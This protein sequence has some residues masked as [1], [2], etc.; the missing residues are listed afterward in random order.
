[1]YAVHF[2]EPDIPR[3]LGKQEHTVE[4]DIGVSEHFV[5]SYT[6]F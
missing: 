2:C 3:L 5:Q 6:W 1:M 4:R